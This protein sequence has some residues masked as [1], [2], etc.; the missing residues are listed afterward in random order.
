MVT[1]DAVPVPVTL[2]VIVGGSVVVVAG[3]NDAVVVVVAGDTWP[4]PVFAGSRDLCQVD[5]GACHMLVMF[6]ASARR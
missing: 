5:S 6:A 2:N 1:K 4:E 3:S